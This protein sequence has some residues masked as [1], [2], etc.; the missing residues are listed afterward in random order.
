MITLDGSKRQDKEPAT[1]K[2]YADSVRDEHD[3]GSP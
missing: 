1:N 3:L 2:K